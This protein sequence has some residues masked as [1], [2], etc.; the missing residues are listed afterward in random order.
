MPG[1]P[2]RSRARSHG[3]ASVGAHRAQLELVGADVGGR[4]CCVQK[5]GVLGSHR[6]HA[7][8]DWL[9]LSSSVDVTP[10]KMRGPS[11]P[12][13]HHP[14]ALPELAE[15][16]RGCG[17]GAAPV[18]TPLQ[19]VPGLTGVGGL[20]R[21]GL[22][23]CSP[24]GL[25]PSVPRGLTAPQTPPALLT[26]RASQGWGLPGLVK[27]FGWGSLPPG[28]VGAGWE[29]QGLSGP[30]IGYAHISKPDALRCSES[31]RTSG[32]GGAGV[33]G[34][35]RR[36]TLTPRCRASLPA[37]PAQYQSPR[38]SKHPH[39]PWPHHRPLP[40][41]GPPAGPGV[42]VPPSPTPP[43]GA[44]SPPPPEGKGY[45]PFQARPA[46]H[47]RKSAGPPREP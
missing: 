19:V 20:Q 6:L 31:L 5:A 42:T 10:Q 2:P 30:G 11:V 33:Q 40:F 21:G 7:G 34:G 15:Q 39:P 9:P 12:P 28:Q 26:S 16:D 8:Q 35:S 44:C 36:P 38:W 43:L 13:A 27:A 17:P 41:G 14:L 46:C 23:G 1:L 18:S 32:V 4:G 37:P 22:S 45:L 47:L 25:L 24:A 3:L 29:P